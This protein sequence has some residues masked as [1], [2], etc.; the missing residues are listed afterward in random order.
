MLTT[1]LSNMFI[2]EDSVADG[3]SY[4]EN[5]WKSNF[6]PFALNCGVGDHNL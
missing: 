4:C 2:V 1:K 6:N 3:L 5:V